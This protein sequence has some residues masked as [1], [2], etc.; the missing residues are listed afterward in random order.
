MLP[1]VRFVVAIVGATVIPY[2]VYALLYVIVRPEGS[3]IEPSSW[4]P[5]V[6]IVIPTYNEENIIE[7]KLEDILSLDYPM[8]RVEV[9]LADASDDGTIETAKSFFEGRESPTLTCLHDEER[10]GVAIAINKA[11]EAATG[12]VIFRTDADSELHPAVLQE[13]TANL[14]HPAI[15]AVTGRQ[16]DVIG[17]SA[18]EAD[19][20]DI[21]SKIQ[22]LESHLD[23]TFIFHG[24]CFAF[25]AEKFSPIDPNS[26]ADDTEVALRIWKGGDRVIMVPTMEFS[27]SGVSAFRKR[28]QRKDRRAMGLIKLLVQN[29]QLLGSDG[30]YGKIVL[31]FNWWFM[32][33]SPW[34]LVLGIL[35]VTVASFTVAGIVG[36]VV[37][38]ALGAFVFLGQRE[39]LGPLQPL[40]AILDSQASLLIA[41]VRLARGEGDGIWEV[42]RKSRELFE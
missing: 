4:E 13:A 24:P 20:R 17:D 28:R 11:V 33:V 7:R 3:P 21:L 37:P 19:Y 31:P 42:D 38:F 39:R 32:V 27:E 40:H 16:T 14:S 36:V 1:Q 22:L 18:V 15:G 41:S 5:S 12:E 2:F 10:Q 25:L 35:A 6:S 29:R 34:L 26:L 9:V 8:E 23:S 30:Q